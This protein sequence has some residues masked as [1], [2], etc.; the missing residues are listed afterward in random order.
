MSGEHLGSDYTPRMSIDIEC[1]DD[2]NK[3]A[4]LR[5]ET[6]MLPLENMN[7]T[8]IEMQHDAH[9]AHAY[10]VD[11]VCEPLEFR[12]E[13]DE[14]RMEADKQEAVNAVAGIVE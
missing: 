7:N 9:N 14:A 5:P 3:L 10:G 4:N 13:I 12:A 2:T 1:V 6:V 11:Q 8:D